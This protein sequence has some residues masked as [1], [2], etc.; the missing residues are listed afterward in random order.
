MP[1]PLCLTTDDLFTQISRSLD[2]QRWF[3]EAHR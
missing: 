2:T 1:E 3:V